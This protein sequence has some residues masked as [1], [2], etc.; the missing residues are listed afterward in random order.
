MSVRNFTLILLCYAC[1][2]RRLLKCKDVVRP[3]RIWRVQ[4]VDTI[5]TGG[6]IEHNESPFA[7]DE[8]QCLAY[9]TTCPFAYVK[10]L[11]VCRAF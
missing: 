7:K 8:V 1:R 2:R 9:V 10:V 11:V 6:G 5:G 3:T 4:L